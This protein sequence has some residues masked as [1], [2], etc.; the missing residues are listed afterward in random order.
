MGAKASGTAGQ[1]KASAAAISRRKNVLTQSYSRTMVKCS[2]GSRAPRQCGRR[3]GI[4][5]S[6]ASR[7]PANHH[8][9]ATTAGF[10]RRH[11]HEMTTKAEGMDRQ[12]PVRFCKYSPRTACLAPKAR[13]TWVGVA[14]H[15]SVRP[16][17][18]IAAFRRQLT[19]CDEGSPRRARRAPWC[20]VTAASTEKTT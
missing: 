11:I 17:K 4:R 18:T 3:G 6:R 15:R 20:I 12:S 8:R 7:R 14:P 1:Q 5:G 19:R 2:S 16:E 10:M 13:R 9:A